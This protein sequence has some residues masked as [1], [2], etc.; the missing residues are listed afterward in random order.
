[1]LEFDKNKMDSMASMAGVTGPG[2]MPSRKT[3]VIGGSLLVLVLGGY[4]YLNGREEGAGEKRGNAAPVRVALV[5]QRDMAV[6]ERSLGTVVAN[7]LVQLSA[8]VQGTLERANFREGDFV[9][10]G[11]LLFVIDPRPFQAAV[12]Q[13]EAIYARDQAQMKNALRDRDRYAALR[14]QGAISV[15]QSDTSQTNADVM[16]ATVAADKAALD[17]ARLNLDYT[18]IRSPV[19]GKTGPILV[20]PG[21]MIS[22]SNGATSALVTI[23]EVRP[24][25]VSFTLPQSEL[26]RIQA[27]QQSK[28][29]L[30]AT[31]DAKDRAGNVLAAPVDFV[32]NMV[33]NQSGSIEL[34][35]NFAN[36]DLS[37][38]PG[39]LVNVT[40]QLNDI[41]GAMVVPRDAVNDSPNGAFLFVVKEG[42]AEQVPVEVQT[43]DGTD[44][45]VAGA[46]LHAGDQVVVE[47]QLRVTAGGKVRVLG[48]PQG[49]AGPKK[50]KAGAKRPA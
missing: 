41:P 37:L 35:A 8:R 33:S 45:A 34:R 28:G 21:N 44:A 20:Q 40:V 16:S 39:Q 10:K 24:I 4:W 38:V 15:Q 19:D 3:W 7:T 49:G 22:S 36:T 18:Q 1:M 26:S 42:K 31:L 25:K 6:V 13:A 14:Q 32:S 30:L 29:V 27:R 50:K 46:G 9:K 5:E 48:K 17:M 12:A 11:D 2:R 47:G 23:A 43:D